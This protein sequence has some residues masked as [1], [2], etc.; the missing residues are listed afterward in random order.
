MRAQG[1]QYDLDQNV[2]HATQAVLIDPD[3]ERLIEIEELHLVDVIPGKKTITGYARGITGKIERDPSARWRFL[4]YLPK[5][6]GEPSDIAFSLNLR[7]VSVKVTDLAAKEPFSRWVAS[8][9][10]KVDGVGDDLLVSGP[11]RLEG[12]GS[13]QFNLRKDKDGLYIAGDG[14]M[15]LAPVI[16]WL[17]GAPEGKDLAWLNDFRVRQLT[18]GGPFEVSYVDEVLS[19]HVP[20]RARFQDFVYGEYS[21]ETG[22]L[23]GTLTET[24]FDG[25][26]TGR[27]GGT[28]ARFEG[29]VR[30]ES[31][32]DVAGRVEARAATVASLPASI[33]RTLPTGTS[34]QDGFIS[35]WLTYRDNLLFMGDAQAAA[36][37]YQGE[38]FRG[39]RAKVEISPVATTVGVSEATYLGQPLNGA[40]KLISNSQKLDGFVNAR[41][42]VLEPIL[43]KFGIEGIRGRG[44]MTAILSGTVKDPQVQFAA[45]GTAKSSMSGTLLDL[46]D[47]T[48]RGTYRN[49]LVNL[50]RSGIRGPSGQAYAGGTIDLANGKLNLDVLASDFPLEAI[51]PEVAGA[52]SFRGV[53]R[54]AL[55]SPVAAGGAEIYNLKIAG[56]EIPVGFA[57]IVVNSQSL[58]AN[59]VVAIRGGSRVQGVAG[60]RWTDQTLFG[61]LNAYGID[62][63]DWFPDQ[64]AGLVDVKDA[65]LGGTLTNP[66]LTAQ[67]SGSNLVV[68]GLKLDDIRAGISFSDGRVRVSDG[69]ARVGEGSITANGDMD[70]STRS[71]TFALDV[72]DLPLG[73]LLFDAA[74]SFNVA[75]TTS[76]QAT[77]VL[78]A[79]ELKSIGATGGVRDLALNETMLGTGDFAAS[80]QNGIWSGNTLIGQIDS[81]LEVSRF[82][83]N[84]VTDDLEADFL[85]NNEP[86]SKLVAIAG[87]YAGDS[88]SP[89]TMMHLQRLEAD[90]DFSGSTSGK[91]T[92]PIVEGKAFTL[93]QITIDGVDA[94]D[95]AAEFSRVDGLWTI[96]NFEWNGPLTQ[97]R[98]ETAVEPVVNRNNSLAATAAALPFAPAVIFTPLPA[99]V[100]QQTDTVQAKF[101]AKGTIDEHGQTQLTGSLNNL[102]ARSLA[103]FMPG[104]GGLDGVFNMP[105]FQ[106]TGPTKTPNIEASLGY[107][108]DV[109][110][111]ANSSRSIDISASIS[112]GLIDAVGLYQLNG[113]TGPIE[114]K[115]PFQYPF[116]I[117]ETGDIQAKITLPERKLA[118]L[119][120]LWSSLDPARTF[121]SIQGE[122]NVT[123]KPDALKFT[124]A[125][126]LFSSDP[127]RTVQVADTSLGTYFTDLD[128]SIIF[129]GQRIALNAKGNSSESGSFAITDVGVG[130][131]DVFGAVLAGD[132]DR[133]YQNNLSGR[134]DLD[135]FKVSYN[136]RTSGNISGTMSGGINLRG[137]V[138]A[139][140]IAGELIVNEGNLAIPTLEGTG[141]SGEYSINP[142]FDLTVNT[143]QPIRFRAGAGQFDLTGN[144]LIRGSLETPDMSATLITQRGSI[145]LPNARIAIEEGGEIRITY[146]TTPT[147]IVASRADLNLEGRTQVTAERFGGGS[148][149]RYDVTLQIRGNLL[150]D[151]GM[152][153]T[154]TSDPPDL[155]QDRILALL[156]QGDFLRSISINALSPTEQI[157]S[158]L[159]G[160]ALPYLA[161]SIT[162][163]IASSLGLDYINVEYSSFD[164][165]TITAALSITRDLVLSGRR[166]ISDPLPGQRTKYDIRLSY[167]PRWA[168]KSLSRVSFSVGLDQ[169]R[170]WK[171]GVEYG[172]K[173]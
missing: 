55:D 13:T 9:E 139:P 52:A 106:V 53:V 20:A 95:V 81:Y 128:A 151:Q 92:N 131:G 129:D 93:N 47:F 15:E 3:G 58:T 98:P 26:V 94:G 169:D 146:R 111:Q 24:G 21:A 149:E 137:T 116:R 110:P 167:R 130:L 134:I 140:V 162:D 132:L 41:S 115:I 50:Q 160:L 42:V 57:D 62:A 87:R 107:R 23:E 166:Q 158:A 30:W 38:E 153:L 173:F 12:A 14:E 135:R 171:I 63:S 126:R 103:V 100:S 165:V 161:G 109:N 45:T 136:D 86:L 117:A 112:E 170:P 138:G 51:S 122:L 113:F 73:R 118:D 148:V 124:G 1:F 85:L 32:I 104:I 172:I 67:I 141:V 123:G 71:G 157:R 102:T 17:R 121:G 27:T 84:P 25:F 96:G 66:T 105:S 49:Q 64:I 108:D 54:G 144:A 142:S 143:A 78:D 76:G 18:A 164:R 8:T 82:Q 43:R 90:I 56:Q 7:D 19:L 88:I 127:Q 34:F 10:V 40:V 28:N 125:A 79:G 33:R 133:F 74:A 29:R 99:I 159:V 152:L 147:G 91:W 70:I 75:G 46:G 36:V 145:R 150:D 60:M 89:E 168:G 6:E 61:S 83:F 48:V 155:S 35:G 59:N 5:Q 4:D 97:A 2:L 120:E 80:Y 101:E 163:K 69:V 154:A 37:R 11:I 16:D 77:V 119:K 44:T 65:N 114:A 22:E 72:S 156:G 31:D 39:I 68:P